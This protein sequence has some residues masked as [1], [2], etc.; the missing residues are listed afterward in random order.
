MVSSYPF[1]ALNFQK[2]KKLPHLV[3]IMSN[4]GFPKPLKSQYGSTYA[5]GRDSENM[6]AAPVKNITDGGL[7]D[8]HYF[9]TGDNDLAV[10]LY[11]KGA[12]PPWYNPMT[13][14]PL[15]TYTF[16]SLACFNRRQFNI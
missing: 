10:L 15:Q 1:T 2:R 11:K 7:P 4:I 9:L 13:K 12:V 14:Q 3:L 8:I 16:L 6:T 5:A